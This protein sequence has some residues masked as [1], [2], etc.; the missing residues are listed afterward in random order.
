MC[1]RYTDTRRDRDFLWRLGLELPQLEF[2][3]RYNLAPTQEAWGG[4]A[5]LRQPAARR[6]CR[7]V[8][9]GTDRDR[10]QIP[11]YRSQAYLP[12][13]RFSL[14]PGEIRMSETKVFLK[15]ATT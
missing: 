11:D 15:S 5:A 6:G 7:Q 8:V 12:P 13:T 14:I 9:R 10:N 1:G 3:P 4:I 2:L